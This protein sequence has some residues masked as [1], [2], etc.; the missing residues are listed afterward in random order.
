M[1][2]NWVGH[3]FLCGAPVIVSQ[4]TRNIADPGPGYLCHTTSADQHVGRCIGNRRDHIKIALALTDQFIGGAKWDVPFQTSAQNDGIS[5]ANNVCN[6]RRQIGKFIH[7]FGPGVWV[8]SR[9]DRELLVPRIS[10][11]SVRRATV[12]AKVHR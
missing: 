5:I 8:P 2:T 4:S 1:D 7:H 10:I 3:I 6:D 12:F 9:A 11:T